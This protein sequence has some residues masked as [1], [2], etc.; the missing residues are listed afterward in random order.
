MHRSRKI[1]QGVCVWGGVWGIFKFAGGGGNQD[2]F[3]VIL[4]CM[5]LLIR[6]LN[7][8]GDGVFRFPSPSSSVH[9]D[10]RSVML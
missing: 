4:L 10:E 3:L 5:N 8:Q 7:F 6:F 1:F 2:I 9:V